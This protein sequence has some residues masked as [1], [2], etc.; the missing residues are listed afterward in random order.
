MKRMAKKY[1][2]IEVKDNMNIN[3]EVED[4]KTEEVQEKKPMKKV[5]SVQPTKVKKGLVSRL[6]TGIVG[7]EGLPGIG[8]YVNEEI[9]KPAVKNIIV[10]AVTSGINMVMY[11]E[12]GGPS[13][14]RNGSHRHRPKTNYNDMHSRGGRPAEPARTQ[15]RVVTRNSRS[16]VEE[17]IIEDRYDAVNVL[18]TLVENADMYDSVSVADYYDLIGVDTQYTDNNVGWTYDTIT[19]ATIVASRSGFIIKFPPTEVI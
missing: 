4:K 2:E 11:G 18:N 9:V 13:R 3:E 10:D 12:K 19:R 8:T 16:R 7:P 17:Y 14:S 1:N 6:V 15:D 5:V